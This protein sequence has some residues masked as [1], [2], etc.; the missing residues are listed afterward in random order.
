MQ[1]VLKKRVAIRRWV[2]VSSSCMVEFLWQ[3]WRLRI[4]LHFC[5]SSYQC[6]KVMT[7]IK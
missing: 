3:A 5:C 2:E 4:H 7:C 1:I 6:M